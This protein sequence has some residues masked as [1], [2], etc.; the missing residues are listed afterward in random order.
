LKEV[1]LDHRGVPRRRVAWLDDGG[2]D[3]FC[4]HQPVGLLFPEHCLI[5]AQL[6]ASPCRAP[7]T[8]IGIKTIKRAEAGE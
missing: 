3:H 7:K 2:L 1:A 5:V 4:G 6:S 8:R